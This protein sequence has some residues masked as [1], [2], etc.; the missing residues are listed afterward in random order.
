MPSTINGIGTHYYGKQNREKNVG[1]CEQC[2]H[3]VEL[4][5]YDTR[6]WF[7]VIFVPLIPLGRKQILD[8]CPACTMHRAIPFAEWEALKQEAIQDSAGELREKQDDP[9]ACLQMLGT[10]A[11]FHK[12][13]EATKLA[14]MLRDQHSEHAL[15][16]FSVGGWLE[17]N[18]HTEEAAAC[19]E[20]AWKLEPDKPEYCRAWGM[21]LAEQGQLSEARAQLSIFEQPETFDPGTIYFLANQ[22]QQHGDHK[23]AIE[24]YGLVLNATPALGKDKDFRRAV[25]ESE[26]AIG[27]EESI[28]PR[29]SIFSS[30][31]FWWAA[32]TCLLV[33]GVVTASQMIASSRTLHVVN[34]AQVP[35][36][37]VIDDRPAI[38]VAALD[39]TQIQLPE[40]S[41]TWAIVEPEALVGQGNLQLSTDF[42]TRLFDSP[43]FV[44]D[45]GRTAVT[46]FEHAVFAERPE[47]G[48]V[49]SRLHACQ[50]FL[51][52]DD[53]DLAF[54]PFPDSIRGER[55]DMER[56]RVDSLLFEPSQVIGAVQNDIT[57]DQQFNFCERH[58]QVRPLNENLL[59][60][61][62][63]LA[64][65]HIATQ[66]MHDFLRTAVDRRPVEIPWHRMYQTSASKLGR[67][68]ELFAEYD[69]LLE[70]N[71]DDSALLYLRGRIEPNARLA[72]ALYERSI[73]ANADNPFPWMAKAHRAMSLAQFEEARVAV[74]K[75]LALRPDHNVE[76]MRFRVRVAQREFEALEQEARAALAE[77]PLDTTAHFRLLTVLALDD[78]PAQLRQAHDVY[79]LTIQ[80]QYPKDP[81]G[82][83]P[84]SDRFVAMC[85]GEHERALQITRSMTGVAGKPQLEAE[86]LIELQ[87]FDELSQ[88]EFTNAGERGFAE[89]YESVSRHLSSAESEWLAAEVTQRALQ[90]LRRGSAE[91]QMVAEALTNG[92]DQS[93]DL[94]D[95]V[96]GITLQP[97]ER[98][99]VCLAA[100][101]SSNGETRNRLL[102]LAE[103]LHFM[104]GFPGGIVT[105][106]IKGLR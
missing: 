13:D 79:A 85:E 84:Q 19:F 67:D 72:G 62:G 57:A 82:S 61:Y 5:T 21:T 50:P 106:S 40:D 92:A 16:Q 103:Q 45:P 14:R 81:F 76:R 3:Q 58:L 25:R 42:V 69:H 43:V 49:S 55:S 15:V 28:L 83:I 98:I 73:A 46:V 2:G 71:P 59:E 75:S 101:V 93:G 6:M 52:F 56:T 66:R 33:G 7:C 41:H 39:R 32:V 86:C 10:L 63:Y 38:H 94:F 4:E 64:V 95:R 23:Q 104:P 35:I 47:D 80:T 26:N 17:Q 53:V 97:H 99:V 96:T 18:E 9:E 105:S 11:A 34:G 87:R 90:N 60:I 78:R 29:R 27:G 65:K 1:V 22:C 91:S 24:L 20:H 74:D 37:V 36:S 68:Q 88:I 100:A 54:E 48:S 89:L 8:Y 44:L 31:G 12:T 51:I 70:N 102:D 30:K 77:S